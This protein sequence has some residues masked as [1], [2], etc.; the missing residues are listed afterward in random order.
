MYGIVSADDRVPFDATEIIARI[1]DGSKFS[2][3]KPEWGESI[4]TGFARIHGHMVGIIAN[5]G[6]IFNESALKATHFIE[7]C[8][9]RRIRLLFLQN[10]SGWSAVTRRSAASPRRGRW[11]QPSPTPPSRSTRC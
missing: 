5:N 1:V 4:V 6:I 7:L 2:P 9:Q 10:T 3:F 11:S 8:E